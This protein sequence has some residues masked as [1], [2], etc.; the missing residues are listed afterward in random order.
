MRT[1]RAMRETERSQRE[2]MHE[3]NKKLQR[4]FIAHEKALNPL[5]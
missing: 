4:L 2:S 3:S 5:D 1:M